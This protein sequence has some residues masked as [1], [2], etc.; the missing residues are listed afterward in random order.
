MTTLSRETLVAIGDAVEA[1]GG[2]IEDAVAVAE[3]WES[4]MA[5]RRGRA[6]RLAY[7]AQHPR[8]HCVDD[9]QLVGGRCSRCY[10]ERQAA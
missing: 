7:E 10:G 4:L 1:A 3:A 6:A 5:D 8:C 2:D 9:P